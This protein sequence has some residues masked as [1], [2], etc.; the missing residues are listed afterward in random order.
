M[1]L[2]RRTYAF[3]HLPKAP[4][5]PLLGCSL[6][7][8]RRPTLFDRFL[9]GSIGQ[10][11]TWIPSFTT[12]LNIIFQ[13]L[14]HFSSVEAV[15]SLRVLKFNLRSCPACDDATEEGFR[16]RRRLSHAD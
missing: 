1:P 6:R 4:H 12:M 3:H 16:S 9:H 2:R 14:D 5:V 15:T 11:N 7:P 8:C 13:E 10:H